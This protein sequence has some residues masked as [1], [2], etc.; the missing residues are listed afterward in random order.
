M[1]GYSVWPRREESSMKF[2]KQSLTAF[3]C[4]VLVV[5]CSGSD[6]GSAAPL[7]MPSSMAKIDAFSGAQIAGGVAD[8]VFASGAFVDVVNGGSGSLV[9]KTDSELS[10]AG[11]SQPGGMLS[12]LAS[13]LIPETTTACAVAGSVTATGQVVDPTT[14]S[15]GDRIMLQFSDCDDGEGQVLNGIYDLDVNSFSGDLLQGL[16]HLNAT[17]NFDGFEVTEGQEKT[18]LIG[19]VALDLDTT[20]PPITRSSVSG[21]SISVSDN[22]DAATLTLFRSDLTHDAGVAPEAYTSAASGTLSSTLFAGNVDYSTPVPFMGYAGEYPFAGELLVTGADGASV[23]LLALDNVNVRL[24][25]DPG[26]GSGIVTQDA[27]WAVLASEVSANATGIS[28]QVLMGPIVPG[29]EVPGQVNEE[30]FSASFRVLHSDNNA[31]GRFKSDDNGNFTVVLPPG[32]YTIV[33]DTSA[34]FPNP[35][36][37]T[38]LVTVPENRFADVILRFDTGIR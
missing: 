15:A 38:K 17:V 34:P 6:G 1:A 30:P 31:V 14:L 21:N 32:E 23:R 5:A 33:P 9:G 29:P 26:D 35:E 11:G 24:Q 8:T 19:G 2:A 36:Q 12:Y 3:L 22:T 20:A 13:A 28:G 37:Q 16:I 27:T 7:P 4:T 10:K 18:S 25:I